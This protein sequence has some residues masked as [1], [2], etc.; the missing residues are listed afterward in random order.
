MNLLVFA[1]GPF[2][3]L[4]LGMPIFLV[5]IGATVA[6][7]LLR[8]DVPL[9]A[10]HTAMF[11]GLDSFAL[12]AV[13]LFILAG[14]LMAQGGIARRLIELALSIVGGVRGSL[15]LATIASASVFGA[16]SGSSV[17]CVAAI[18]KLTLPAL[19]QKGYGR[20]YGVSLITATGVIDVIIP[21][22]I[23]MIIYAIAAQVSVT[24]LFLAGIVPGIIIALCLAVYVMVK[25]HVQMI[26]LG[27]PA[28]WANI[29]STFKEA[30]WALMAPVV[31]L[32]GIYGGIFTPTEAA[33]IACIYAVVISV[34]V[35]KEL[36]WAG[37][38]KILLESTVLIAQ[39]MIIVSAAA[40]YAWLIT[41]SGIAQALVAYI[42]SI[43]MQT[44]LLLMTINI[45]LLF[46]GSMLEPPAAILLLTPLLT[47]VVAAAGIDPIHFGL[48]VTV[49]LAVG[50]FL[51]PFGLNLFASHALF[52]TPLP[53]LYR[54]VL[55][56]LGIYIAVLILLTYVPAIT[57]LPLK[58]FE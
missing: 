51:P 47:P 3:L 6:G 41:T 22:S 23:P 32:G 17:A 30:V 43:G 37:V 36:D 28:R 55:P 53:E 16:M 7:V 33:G 52:G 44:W 20:T 13:P 56:F 35:Y 42:Q 40:A 45:L 38:W 1:G 57:L 50:L 48:V 54:G 12:L 34:F 18:G 14:D 8:G 29:W 11:G 39:I 24:K 21:P 31:I 19:E 27:E 26:P 5:L 10:I 15:A 2:A 49:N 4:A 58:L 46:V 9:Q 25:A